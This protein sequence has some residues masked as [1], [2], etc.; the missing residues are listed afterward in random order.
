MEA[1]GGDGPKEIKLVNH[2]KTMKTHVLFA[3]MALAAITLVS[4]TQAATTNHLE[5]VSLQLI[6]RSQLPNVTNGDGTITEKTMSSALTSSGLIQALGTDTNITTNGFS[7]KAY[8]AFDT[9]VTNG[10]NLPAILVVVEGTGTNKTITPVDADCAIG[11][12]STVL[13]DGVIRTNGNHNGTSFRIR[14]LDI[15]IT[16]Q[17]SLSLSG[18]A[19]RNVLNFKQGGGMSAIHVD[20]NDVYWTLSGYGDE[21]SD[22]NSTPVIVTGTLSA[23]HF[24]TS[25]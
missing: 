10:T 4:A 19:V 1:H 18:L 9:V 21:G 14:T 2:V 15:N 7:P 6:V 12:P 20:D 16:N 23:H 3:S 24:D 25:E 17:W 11:V 22:T 5:K 8:L 13:H